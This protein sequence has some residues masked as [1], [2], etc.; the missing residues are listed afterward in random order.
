MLC[1]R[2]FLVSF[3]VAALISHAA[4]SWA[5]RPCPVAD[6]G[7]QWRFR[8]VAMTVDGLASEEPQLRC[9]IFTMGASASVDVSGEPGARESPVVAVRGPVVAR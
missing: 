9:V 8:S 1:H 5:T 3:S 6:P 2:A 4:V 7:G